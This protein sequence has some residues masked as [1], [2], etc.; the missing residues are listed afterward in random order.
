MSGP[1]DGVRVLDFSTMVSGPVAARMLADQG[2]DVIKVE[3]PKGDE[4][5]KIGNQRNGLTAV[6][7]SCNRGKRGICLD[8]KNE[9]ARHALSELVKSV[10]VIIQNFRPGAM[11]RIGFDEATV[12]A[13][14]KD[15]IYVSISGFGEQ[16]PYAHQRVYDPIIQALCGATDIQADRD[17][18]RPKMF[19]II[20]ADKVTSLTAAQAV[21]SALYAREKTGKGDHIKLSMLDAMVSFFWPE[22]M[23][24]ITFVGDEID[25]TKYQGTMDLIYE[26]TNGYMTAGAV[27]DDEWR[28]MCTALNKTE[29]IEDER[30]NNTTVR[31]KNAELRKQMTAAEIVKWDRQEIL[32]RLDQQGVPSAPLLSRLDLL[33]DEQIAANGTIEIYEWEGHGQVR[34][35][36]P[37]ATFDVHPGSVDRAAPLMGEHNVE[38]LQEIG[39]SNA[40]IQTLVDKAA[41]I[42][43][44]EIG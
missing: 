13:I 31:F 19:R 5:R 42:G 21:S 37:A 39:Y 30:F 40:D 17:S 9:D 1:L 8:L 22:G 16:G 41:L 12:R 6:F 33:D 36:R 34:Q 35:A 18:G 24:G 27:S 2:A 20:I 11:A 10:D 7:M 44:K 38:I 3:S 29:W 43:E 23:S 26:T 28:G 14:K 4:M 25:V 32:E 15:I